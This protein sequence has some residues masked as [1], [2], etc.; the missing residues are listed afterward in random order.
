[1]VG[2]NQLT[3][4]PEYHLVN[5]GQVALTRPLHHRPALGQRLEFRNVVYS[6]PTVSMNRIHAG[7][8]GGEASKGCRAAAQSGRTTTPIQPNS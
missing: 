5:I 4:S 1:M 6:K 8:A 7:R 3:H 2:P